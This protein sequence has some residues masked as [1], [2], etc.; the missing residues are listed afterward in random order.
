MRQEIIQQVLRFG[1]VGSI[2]FVVDGGLL[3]FFIT[4]G[5]DP[6]YARL[7]SFPIAVLATWWLN[8][9]WTFEN[10]DR[11]KPFSQFKRYMAIQILGAL[12]NY[13]VYALYLWTFNAT[14]G[15][16]MIGFA[17]GSTLGMFVNFIGVRRLVFKT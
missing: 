16:A 4:Q 11:A 1:G 6:Y 15:N 5:I 10:A 14:A 9:I 7:M 12:T 17:L 13:S 2:G 3:W 8:R